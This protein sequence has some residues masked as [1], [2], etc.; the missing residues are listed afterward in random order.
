MEDKIKNTIIVMVLD[1]SGSMDSCKQGTIDGFN[2]YVAGMRKYGNKVRM[3][4]T[5]FNSSKTQIVHSNVPIKDVAGLSNLSYHP[6]E[7][8]P[9]YD[10]IGVSIAET[11]EFLKK[12]GEKPAVLFVII[13][14]GQENASRV[15]DRGKIFLM[16]D[17]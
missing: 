9:L 17:E 3:T 12:K 2:E 15:H 4:L 16:I 8:T 1:E 13:T 14:D 6:S 5:K 7:C 11:D 10:A